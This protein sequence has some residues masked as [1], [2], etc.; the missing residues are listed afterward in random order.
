MVGDNDW[1][2]G[3]IYVF[4]KM[5]YELGLLAGTAACLRLETGCTTVPAG[6]KS[7]FRLLLPHYLSAL[8]I[9]LP[10]FLSAVFINLF[11]PRKTDN[12]DM[13]LLL[14]GFQQ[15]FSRFWRF[16]RWPKPGRAPNRSSTCLP[17]VMVIGLRSGAQNPTSSEE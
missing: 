15:G 14:S 12:W 13:D 5:A 10:G 1:G 7:R 11:L 9:P 8:V 3:N 6:I 4:T 17:S 16:F 2:T